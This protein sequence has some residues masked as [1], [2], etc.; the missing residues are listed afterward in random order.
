MQSVC[1]G[2]RSNTLSEAAMLNIHLCAGV[3]L[4]F[5]LP[6]GIWGY[7]PRGEHFEK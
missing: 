3:E 2:W 6:G 1:S 4:G 7:A 5:V